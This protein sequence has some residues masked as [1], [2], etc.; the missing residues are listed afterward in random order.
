MLCELECLTIGSGDDGPALRID[1][2]LNIG[3]TCSCE[4]FGS[5]LLIEGGQKHV[6]DEFQATNFEVYIL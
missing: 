3:R 1:R 4:T 5:L 2:D 6:D